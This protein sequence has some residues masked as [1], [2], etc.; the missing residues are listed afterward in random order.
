L[1]LKDLARAPA[2]RTRAPVRPVTADD[3]LGLFVSGAQVGVRSEDKPEWQF[4][5]VLLF[6]ADACA[7]IVDELNLDWFQDER[8][9]ELV[10]YALALWAEGRGLS[11]VELRDRVPDALQD[12]LDAVEPTEGE[13]P[14]RV[15]RRVS[16]F[17]DAL[18][19]RHLRRLKAGARDLA[20]TL[21]I[22]KRIRALEQRKFG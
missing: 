21:E 9:R 11:L 6:Y 1:G 10:D 2:A 17:R 8:V 20:E 13:E 3:N 7:G 14:D 18:E 22:Q 5:Q 16:D 12:A 15:L 19:M 4:L